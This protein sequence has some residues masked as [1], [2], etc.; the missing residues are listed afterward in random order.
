MIHGDGASRGE[1]RA[2]AGK[3]RKI[4]YSGRRHRRRSRSRI[5]SAG[6]DPGLSVLPTRRGLNVIVAEAM[7]DAHDEDEQV[8]GFYNI[9]GEEVAVS[10]KTTVPGS[11]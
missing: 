9:L 2:E 3:S 6:A 11:Q 7:V 4:V 10:F 5:G 1:V 8:S